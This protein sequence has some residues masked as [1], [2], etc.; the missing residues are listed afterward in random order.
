MDLHGYNTAAWDGHPMVGLPSKF[1]LTLKKNSTFIKR[2]RNILPEQVSTIKEEARTLLI[3][4]YV[5]E[6]ESALWEGLERLKPDMVDD[7]VEV[8]SVLHQRLEAEITPKLMTRM[9]ATIVPIDTPVSEDLTVFRRRQRVFVFLL[10]AL[11]EAGVLRDALDLV[12]NELPP[13]IFQRCQKQANYPIV[14]VVLK[15]VLSQDIKSGHAVSLALAFIRRFRDLI[16]GDDLDRECQKQLQ[17]IFEV[18]TKSSVE[19][20]TSLLEKRHRVHQA[21]R[22]AVIRVGRMPEEHQQ[23]KD[24]VDAIYERFNGITYLAESIGIP[25]PELPEDEEM[26]LLKQVGITPQ[27]LLQLEEQLFAN[28]EERSHYTKLPS[29]LLKRVEATTKHASTERLW[30][31]VK[32]ILSVESADSAAVTYLALGKDASK[33]HNRILEILLDPMVSN[34]FHSRFLW[35]VGSPASSLVEEISDQIRAKLY[36]QTLYS[37]ALLRILIELT[38]FKLVPAT[39]IFHHLHLMVKNIWN[40]ELRVYFIEYITLCGPILL[41]DEEYSRD[42]VELIRKLDRQYEERS[43]PP[44]DKLDIV[45]LLTPRNDLRAEHTFAPSPIERLVGRIVLKY[46]QIRFDLEKAKQ[47]MGNLFTHSAA[48]QVLKKIVMTPEKQAWDNL[49][50]LAQVVADVPG[51]I[52]YAVDS[53]TEEILRGLE[54][55]N[56]SRN[57]DRHVHVRYLVELYNH[58]VVDLEFVVDIALMVLSFGYPG[59]QPFPGLEV[60]AD[61]SHD[62][63]RVSLISLMLK[64]MAPVA[65]LAQLRRLAVFFQ[66]YIFC[67]PGLSPNLKIR[68]QEALDKHSQEQYKSLA[69]CVHHLKV[70]MSEEPIE[71]SNLQ[72]LAADVPYKVELRNTNS[73]PTDNEIQVSD[74]FADSSSDD[75]SDELIEHES[76]DS[77]SSD[78]DFESSNLIESPSH[79]DTDDDSDFES[80]EFETDEHTFTDEEEFGEH[81]EAKARRLA[82]QAFEGRKNIKPAPLPIPQSSVTRM[83]LLTKRKEAVVQ[84]SLQHSSEALDKIKQTKREQETTRERIMHLVDNMD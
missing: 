28:S 37:Y 82:A 17:R 75:D 29:D 9:V 80:S 72:P 70:V 74:E 19:V 55:N 84:V 83:V 11:Y 59:G 64:L 12:A 67:K 76:D 50:L 4:K 40:E 39:I 34:K 2:L 53:V 16:Y 58:G 5:P 65:K 22:K 32:D 23:Q 30:T 54:V 26:I 1:D 78:S 81:L 42:M 20:Y 10:M 31:Q 3:T 45:Q 27:H 25:L 6:I 14:V 15:M 79:E 49:G 66:F 52:P 7:A 41:L 51:L 48:H 44:K 36:S 61:P 56:S 38:R 21:C 47:I 24:E 69:E 60:S 46:G 63:S 71:P 13:V 35:V 77:D 62:H 68:V 43:S 33:L 57:R 18:Y 73:T 8:V